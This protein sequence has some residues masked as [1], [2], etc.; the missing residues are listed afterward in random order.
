MMEIHL[1][2]SSLHTG[3]GYAVAKLLMQKLSVEMAS[4]M[5]DRYKL[6]FKYSPCNDCNV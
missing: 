3:K 5:L 2:V 6:Q 1:F 4:N